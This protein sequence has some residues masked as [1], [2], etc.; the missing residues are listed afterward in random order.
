MLEIKEK[1]RIYWD[2]ASFN[3]ELYQDGEKIFEQTF[4]RHRYTDSIM[5]DVKLSFCQLARVNPYLVICEKELFQLEK[6]II[7]D[8]LGNSRIFSSMF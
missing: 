3:L 6:K 1:V 8:E 4:L 5:K 7:L 2:R